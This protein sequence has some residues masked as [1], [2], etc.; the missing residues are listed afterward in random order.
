MMSDQHSSGNYTTIPTVAW[1]YV[2]GEKIGMLTRLAFQY[3]CFDQWRPRD[4]DVSWEV[5]VA[6]LYSLWSKSRLPIWANLGVTGEDIIRRTVRSKIEEVCDLDE[7]VMQEF[8]D[9]MSF[10]LNCN[11]SGSGWEV[12]KL[13]G[14]RHSGLEVFCTSFP[15]G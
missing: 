15:Q 10:Q 11:V 1:C 13:M 6:Y 2:A 8:L 9:W 12:K 5:A 7:E 14:C 3:D 4:K